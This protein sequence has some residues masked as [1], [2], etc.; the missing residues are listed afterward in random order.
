MIPSQADEGRA[1]STAPGNSPRR[2]SRMLHE[3]LAR[4][5]REGGSSCPEDHGSRGRG[6][7]MRRPR[8]PSLPT[9]CLPSRTVARRL[10][11]G[12][13]QEPLRIT[14]PPGGAGGTKGSSVR[15]PWWLSDQ[16]SPHQ[17]GPGQGD[18]PPLPW[19]FRQRSL[20]HPTRRR[21]QA[22]PRR[23]LLH[24]AH[25][26]HVQISPQQT[27]GQ[28]QA[29]PVRIGPHIAPVRRRLQLR[30]HVEDAADAP[31]LLGRVGI[32]QAHQ[33]V[34]GQ[35]AAYLVVDEHVVG[36]HIPVHQAVDVGGNQPPRRPLAERLDVGRRGLSPRVQD[37]VRRDLPG[38]EREHQV[39][40]GRYRIDAQV[41]GAPGEPRPSVPVAG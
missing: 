40:S 34:V 41:E 6:R 22:Q 23:K 4:K 12:L 25:I 14:R 30:C 35:P 33:V 3:P 13:T 32:H 5:R 27:E 20:P 16:L 9:R 37:L 38:A 39:D 26:S 17:A 18:L 19:P 21:G 2:P 1:T 24:H 29:E 10:T 8:K 11:A 15:R 31:G 7:T 36:L 28:R